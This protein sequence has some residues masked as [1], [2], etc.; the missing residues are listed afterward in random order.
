VS[1]GRT[2]FDPFFYAVIAA[3]V[4]AGLLCLLLAAMAS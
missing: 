3:S 1:G 4:A 2:G